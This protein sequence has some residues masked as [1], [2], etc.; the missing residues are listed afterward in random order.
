[1]AGR[2]MD[3]CRLSAAIAALLLWLHAPAALMLGPLLAAIAF[4]AGGGKVRAASPPFVVAQGVVGCM[5]AKMMP[6]VDRRRNR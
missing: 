5:I 3:C 4:A 1:M 6:A 2:S